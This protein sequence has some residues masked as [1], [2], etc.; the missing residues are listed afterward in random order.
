ME[1]NTET[2]KIKAALVDAWGNAEDGYEENDYMAYTEIEVPQ[3]SLDM[4]IRSHSYLQLL[5][6]KLGLGHDVDTS[7]DD[8]YVIRAKD[9]EPLIRIWFDA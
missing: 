9:G 6:I 5:D 1:N 8:S 2:V 4:I 7:D 3:A